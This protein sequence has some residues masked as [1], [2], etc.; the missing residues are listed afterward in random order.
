MSQIIRRLSV[1]P[2]YKDAMHYQVGKYVAGGRL[3][4]DNIVQT[5]EGGYDIYVS[6]EG[7]DEIFK[8][9]HVNQYVPAKIENNID[10]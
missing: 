2:D 3:L 4:I 6:K 1:G 10:F 8:W 7:S 9:K 5:D